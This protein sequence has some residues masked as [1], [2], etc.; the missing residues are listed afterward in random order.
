MLNIFIHATEHD[1]MLI[2]YL[3][4]CAS[5]WKHLHLLCFFNQ[6]FRF[7]LSF[8]TVVCISLK[9]TK[10]NLLMMLSGG[11]DCTATCI[12]PRGEGRKHTAHFLL[13][14][15]THIC[16]LLLHSHTGKGRMCSWHL[17]L[18]PAGC[19]TLMFYLSDLLCGL[20]EQLVLH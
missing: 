7:F 17:I 2:A 19:L 3:P 1:W 6:L 14:F 4:C 13:C 16:S 9:A 11:E 12:K 18:L 8:V 10:V 15:S 5:V 20:R